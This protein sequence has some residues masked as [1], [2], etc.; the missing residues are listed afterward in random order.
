MIAKC[1]Y[2]PKVNEKR[3]KQVCFNE[4][5]NRECNNGENNSYQKIYAPL[6]R[7]S[8][9]DEC[10]RGKFGDNSQLT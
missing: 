5:G 6:A 9:N 3:K 4:K 2:P 1:P 7:M 10:P 8:G